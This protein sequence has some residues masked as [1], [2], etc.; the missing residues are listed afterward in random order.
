[1]KKLKALWLDDI[2]I[3]TEVLEGY[4]DWV[5]VKNYNEFVNYIINNGMP[6]I[7]SMD[8]DLH[9]EHINDYAEQFTKMGWQSP[10]Y[11]EYI[12]KTG[13][14]CAKFICDVY[15]TSVSMDAPDSP[16]SEKFPRCIVH[17]HN[18]VGCTNIISYIN[19]FIKYMKIDSVCYEQRLP[20]TT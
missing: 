15:Q 7:I 10:K 11:N 9:D 8:H 4:E 18:P 16:H 14:D 12:E 19:G 17:S 6:D 2:R 20:F 13:L 3:P 1:M 5:I